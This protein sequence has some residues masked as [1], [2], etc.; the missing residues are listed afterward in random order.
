MLQGHDIFFQINHEGNL[1]AF[2]KI[3]NICGEPCPPLQEW[4]TAEAAR[5]RREPAWQRRSRSLSASGATAGALADAARALNVDTWAEE[6]E[7][8][9]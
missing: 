4:Q 6:R 2:L 1:K 3:N 9:C 7:I 5:Q 8:R